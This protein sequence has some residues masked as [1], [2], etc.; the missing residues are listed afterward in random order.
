MRYYYLIP[1][2][3][4]TTT[5]TTELTTELTTEPTPEVKKFKR[6]STYPSGDKIPESLPDSYQ[7]HQDCI[8]CAAFDEKTSIC[9]GYNA[10]VQSNYWCS[11]W[12][13]RA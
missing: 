4:S 13:A 6:G 1:T 8:S 10:P 2:T 12:K 7:L 3:Q 11:S 5:P 9:T